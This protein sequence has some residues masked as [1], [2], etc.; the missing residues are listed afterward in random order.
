MTKSPTQ[1]NL[2]KTRIALSRLIRISANCIDYVVNGNLVLASKE[3][4]ELRYYR[5]IIEDEIQ[6]G[7]EVN[8]GLMPS[9]VDDEEFQELV[10]LANTVVNN[11]NVIEQWRQTYTE[12]ATAWLN[13]EEEEQVRLALDIL[14]PLAW[15]YYCDLIIMGGFNTRLAKK[16]LHDK[17]QR[18][19]IDIDEVTA[20]FD[21]SS[22]DSL[23]GPLNITSNIRH[24][25]I[26]PNI[27]KLSVLNLIT[28]RLADLRI[29]FN[30]SE[31]FSKSWVYQQI[32]NL[33][34]VNKC[35]PASALISFFQGRDILIISPGPSL[36]TNI[37]LAKNHE[38]HFII[39]C[40]AQSY[41]AL[42]KH[43]IEPDFVIVI[44]AQDYSDSLANWDPKSSVGII[45][46]EYCHPNFFAIPDAN[47]FI[48][49]QPM[50]PPLYDK[51]INEHWVPRA[52]LSVSTLAVSLSCELGARSVTLIGQ[53]L[54]ISG[55]TYYYRNDAII[56]SG[57]DGGKSTWSISIPGFWGGTVETKPDYLFYLKELEVTAT[58]FEG[59]VELFN[60]TEGGAYISG[61]EHSSLK[62][63]I[64]KLTSKTSKEGISCNIKNAPNSPTLALDLLTRKESEIRAILEITRRLHDTT[65]SGLAFTHIF[66]AAT[67]ENEA[68]LSSLIDSDVWI[69]LLTA[70]ESA[71][72][73]RLA[74]RIGDLDNYSTVSSNYY[75]L[76]MTKCTDLL[77]Q[78][79]DTKEALSNEST[80][81]GISK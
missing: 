45:L 61:F 9:S 18:R 80:S 77:I 19:I 27:A 7:Q 34:Y 62:D 69:K 74:H 11:I 37:E 60:C 70:T 55:G 72:I 65:K 39:V 78:I 26:V 44:D 57:S 66:S 38:D 10:I 5:A 43:N 79:S 32:E 30:T 21:E 67:T 22:V 15:N 2:K 51:I 17:G 6:I 52:Q 59:T 68:I 64:Q 29:G 54:S 58:L 4:D 49:R 1:F 35:F 46:G 28:D 40:P 14:V 24:E 31:Y 76:I 53:D 75:G 42:H 81:L 73:N 8:D 13:S 33:K 48:L 3:F 47:I 20:D 41:Q 12:D 50:L 16:I 36:R 23:F 25:T 63:R 56:N 71:R